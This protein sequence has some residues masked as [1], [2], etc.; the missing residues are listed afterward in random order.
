M[1]ELQNYKEMV[2]SPKSAII[3]TEQDSDIGYDHHS[4]IVDIITIYALGRS[5]KG[6]RFEPCRYYFSLLRLSL[7][8]GEC[9]VMN[10]GCSCQMWFSPQDPVHSKFSFQSC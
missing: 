4:N 1:V 2:Q 9:T 8:S 5:P 6:R 10:D 3:Y 7:G